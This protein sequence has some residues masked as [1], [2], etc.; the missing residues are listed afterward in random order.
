MWRQGGAGKRLALGAFALI[1]VGLLA[2]TASL[3]RRPQYRVL[4]AH[5]EPQDAAEVVDKL[6]ELKTPYRVGSG[7]TVEVPAPRVEELRLELASAGLPEGAQ[8]GFELLDRNRLG[9]SDFGEQV[10]YVR[11]LQGELARTIAHLEAVEQAR[12]HIS[13]PKERLY[14]QE[15]EQA[16]ASVVLKLRG[17]RQLGDSQVASIVHLVSGAV[18]GLAPEQV[19]V[20]DTRGRLLSGADEPRGGAGI[21]AASGQ[22]QLRRDYEQQIERAV[23]SMLDGV[24][25]PGSAVVRVSAELDLDQ[26]ETEREIYQPAA[27][28]AGVLLSRRETREQ[29]RGTGEP[30]AIGIPGISSNT[31]APPAVARGGTG[32]DQYERTEV[33][34]DYRV[35][36]EVERRVR[37]PGDVRRLSVA[38]LVDEQAKVKRLGDL[39]QAVAAAAGLSPER[40]D[41]VVV[42]QAP[43]QAPKEEPGSRALAVRDFYFRV[44]RDFVAIIMVAL[45]ARIVLGLLRG[46]SLAS[47]Q[48]S[49]TGGPQGAAE[50]PP[51]SQPSPPGEAQVTEAG[52]DPDRAA[53]V[54]RQWLSPDRV[55]VGSAPRAGLSAGLPSE[56]G[57]QEPV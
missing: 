36:R 47:L 18:E 56:L 30:A 3:A 19:T 55:A 46:R 13:L 35:S 10:N 25:G 29:Y 32:T 26:V 15:H 9:L 21:G 44:G 8:V 12:V 6:R 48:A 23:Q 45:F 49:P 17:G 39:R 1:C 40:G 42:S 5:L 16:S 27:A 11:A 53:A 51:A 41:S 7:G 4:Y 52:F 43:F 24:V 31:A 54:V 37:P 38:V 57:T 28:G 34:S 20:V 2:L 50:P 33:A 22:F 14:E